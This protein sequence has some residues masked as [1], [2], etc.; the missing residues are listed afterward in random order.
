MYVWEVLVGHSTP[1]ACADG[2]GGEF[3]ADGAVAVGVQGW[4]S[5]PARAG[6]QRTS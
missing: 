6:T 1:A 4:C 2:A 5:A 3:R